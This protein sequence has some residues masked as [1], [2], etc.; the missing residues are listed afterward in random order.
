MLHKAWP[1]ELN[2]NSKSSGKEKILL[3]HL[4]TWSTWPGFLKFF[5]KL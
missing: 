4:L 3:N 5:G 2:E 1:P